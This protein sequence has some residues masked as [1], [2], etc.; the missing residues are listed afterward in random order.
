MF[1]LGIMKFVRVLTRKASLQ[2]NREDLKHSSACK[3]HV[4]RPF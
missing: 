3:M 4:E 2:R 1:D